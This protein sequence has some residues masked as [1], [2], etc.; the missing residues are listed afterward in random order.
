MLNFSQSS[1]E[2]RHPGRGHPAPGGIAGVKETRRARE[3]TD[4][5]STSMSSDREYQSER[6]WGGVGGQ[7]EKSNH[8]SGGRTLSAT[9]YHLATAGM[10]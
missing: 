10:D 4:Q 7:R 5:I 9:G 3:H 2:T 6:G 1:S 8:A